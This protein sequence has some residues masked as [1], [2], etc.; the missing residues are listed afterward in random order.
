MSSGSAICILISLISY[1]FV[2]IKAFKSMIS[3]FARSQ[4]SFF[5]S[6][7]L[8]LLAFFFAEYIFYSLVHIFF[9]L[10]NS[11]I[12]PANPLFCVLLSANYGLQFWL[13]PS[14]FAKA[15]LSYQAALSEAR[16]KERFFLSNFTSFVYILN[17]IVSYSRFKHWQL[18]KFV[19]NFH[20]YAIILFLIL[21]LKFTVSI[22]KLVNVLPWHLYVF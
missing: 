11:S 6:S 2:L 8:R 19:F 3:S 9:T 5:F 4:A 10:L 14:S 17:W 21:F 7:S 1:S 15:C 20:F 16:N 13:S 18:F 22:L 12:L